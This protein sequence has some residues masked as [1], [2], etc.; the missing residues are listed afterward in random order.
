MNAPGGHHWAF[1]VSVAAGSGVIAVCGPPCSGK[2]RSVLGYL[3][4]RRTSAA[5]PGGCAVIYS[6]A[7]MVAAGELREAVIMELFSGSLKRR[8]TAV[9]HQTFGHSVAH[10]VR[11]LPHGSELHV[12]IDDVD[13][14]VLEEN[15]MHEW[16]AV[17]TSSSAAAPRARVFFWILSQVPLFLQACRYHFIC[18]PPVDRIK[19]WLNSVSPKCR[20]AVIYYMTRN[21]TALSIVAQDFRTLLVHVATLAMPHLPVVPNALDY[22]LAWKRASQSASAFLSVEGTSTNAS[23]IASSLEELGPSAQVLFAA[24]F[25]CGCVSPAKDAQILFAGQEKTTKRAQQARGPAGLLSARTYAFSAH[26]LER[27][28]SKLAPLCNVSP[29][30]VLASPVALHHMATFATWGV[31]CHA[32]NCREKWHSGMSEA[33]VMDV[34]RSLGLKL[35]DLIK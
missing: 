9:S 27:V 7:R 34:A 25:Y 31:V 32:V 14:K 2:S 10:F 12:V 19:S 5:V 4:R 15:A 29:T 23:V 18:K 1:D 22:A 28:Y 24:C 20:D 35:Q 3:F 30:Q 8:L 21:P 26:R 6:S 13:E 11:H 17:C 33:C 16:G